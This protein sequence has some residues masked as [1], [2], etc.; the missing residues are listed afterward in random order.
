MAPTQKPKR[1]VDERKVAT[2]TAEKIAG[3][4]TG[5]IAFLNEVL[6]VI[7]FW[8]RLACLAVFTLIVADLCLRSKWTRLHIPSPSKRLFLSMG[9]FAV[10]VVG[11]WNPMRHQYM[12]EHLPPSFPFI[13]GGPLGDNDSAVWKMMVHHYGPSHVSK[14]RLEFFDEE[15]KKKESEWI[16]SHHSVYPPPRELVGESQKQFQI[17]EADPMPGYWMGDFDWT[18]LDPNHQHYTVGIQCPSAYFY[19]DLNVVRVEGSLYMEIKI[20]RTESWLKRNPELPRL[21][22]WCGPLPPIPSDPPPLIRRER[23]PHW[24]PNHTYIKPVV[25]IDPNNHIQIATYNFGCWNIL[26]DHFGD[27]LYRLHCRMIRWRWQ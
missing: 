22:F 2:L 24:Q 16:D 12:Q 18:P 14:C 26:T 4:I 25:I 1:V 19:E 17:P 27:S 15:R 11:L 10:I 3:G 8:W 5:T 13:V 21:V 7:P 9:M 23:N 20:E 6:P